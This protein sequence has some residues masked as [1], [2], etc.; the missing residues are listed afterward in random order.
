MCVSPLGLVGPLRSNLE[1][2]SYYFFKVFLPSSLPAFGRDMFFCW[3]DVD[4]LL[5]FFRL[6]PVFASFWVDSVS[7]SS[8]PSSLLLWCLSCC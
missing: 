7:V 2:S 4:A 5:L 3:F 8:S 1:I 6:F